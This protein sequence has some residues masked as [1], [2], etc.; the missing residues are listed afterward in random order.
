MW[1]LTAPIN[2]LVWPKGCFFLLISVLT[3]VAC[4]G[5]Q[6]FPTTSWTP[7][8]TA[9][10][11]FWCCLHAIWTAPGQSEWSD[12][13]VTC[14]CLSAS[15][16]YPLFSFNPLHSIAVALYVSSSFSS[17]SLSLSLS[18]CLSLSVSLSVCLSVCL[19]LSLSLS[20]WQ[21][22]V[23]A[24]QANASFKLVPRLND[25][26]HT[27]VQCVFSLLEEMLFLGLM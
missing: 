3:R 20:Q 14:V 17:S 13:S 6:W 15:L 26:E 18:L 19:F 11:S 9:G 25:D 1:R 4:G 10:G 16:L 12:D 2:S 21:N 27:M 24:S 8:T 22:I 23:Y 5:V 7:W